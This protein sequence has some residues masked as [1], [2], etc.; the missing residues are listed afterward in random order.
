MSSVNE[1]TAAVS[2]ILIDEDTLQN[3][4]T[5]LGAEI[6]DDYRGRDLLL[7]GVLKGAFFFIAGLMRRIG[8]PCEIDFLTLSR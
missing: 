1:L 2:E 6:G 8:I 7:V 4:I 5:D 3:R